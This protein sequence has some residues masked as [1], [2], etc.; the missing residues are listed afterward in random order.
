[1]GRIFP[2]KDNCLTDSMYLLVANRNYHSPIPIIHKMLKPHFIWRR[3]ILNCTAQG[4]AVSDG[5]W[6]LDGS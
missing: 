4:G 3:F 6:G 2:G 1:M 5:G